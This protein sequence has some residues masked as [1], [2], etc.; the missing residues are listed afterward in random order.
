M[1]EKPQVSMS[2]VRRWSWLIICGGCILVVACI[3]LLGSVASGSPW[4]D[5]ASTDVKAYRSEQCE[6]IDKTAFFLQIAN[7]WSNFA[8]LA[9]GLMILFFNRSMPGRFIGGSLCFLALCSA[10]FHGTLTGLGQTLDIVGVYAVLLAIVAYGFIELMNWEYDDWQSWALMI[11]AVVVAFIGGFLRSEVIVF[12]SDVFTP[13]LVVVIIGW[14]VWSALARNTPRGVEPA[15]EGNMWWGFG[16]TVSAGLFALVFKYTDGT[17]NLLAKH[18]GHYY[19]CLYSHTSVIQGHALWHIFTAVMFVGMF[20]Y[21]RA[22]RMRSES[23]FP[24]RHQ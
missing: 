24:W 19:E 15:A 16:I 1:S 9:A 12:N 18:D 4:A 20:E 3:A 8:Y 11:G 10:W 14:M 2:L 5:V 7:F 23:P 21:F 22:F 6:A 13:A 17:D